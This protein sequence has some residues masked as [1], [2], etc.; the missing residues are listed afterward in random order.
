MPRNFKKHLSTRTG[1]RQDYLIMCSLRETRN[2]LFLAHYENVIS[3]EEFLLLFDVNRSTNPDL[4][5][6]LYDHFD[7]NVLENDECVTEFRFNKQ[8]LPLLA[9]ALQIPDQIRCYQRSVCS[10]LEAL[11]I[12]LKRLSYPCRYADM[13][14]SFG[15]P[16]PTLCMIFNH[17]IDLIYETHSH[18]LLAWNNG[19]LNPRA[20]ESYAEAITAKG[21]P[22]TNCFGF[23][24]GT[25][26]P[27]CRPSENQRMVYNGHKRVHALKFQAVALPNGI[28]G[29][30]Y[31]PVGE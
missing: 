20:L 15:R 31:G 24:D 25:V 11:C 2:Q 6:D 17:M 16:V 26:R 27:I 14:R 18:R 13:I 3:D 21:S 5:Y 19:V 10:R 4:P 1:S 23:I 12:L 28:I 30:M 7:F 8:D 29:N 22:L 9:E